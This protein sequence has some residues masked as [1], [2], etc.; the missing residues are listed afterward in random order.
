MEG[1]D[2]TLPCKYNTLND[3][4]VEWYKLTELGGRIRIIKSFN[5]RI[6]TAGQYR[7]RV[8]L[9]TNEGNG[10]LTMRAIQTS[11]AGRYECSVSV[12]NNLNGVSHLTLQ[13]RCLIQLFSRTRL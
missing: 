9:D 5:D 12:G 6:R 13:V 2:I 3:I 1:V 8:Y 11:D 7:N 4:G 10:S